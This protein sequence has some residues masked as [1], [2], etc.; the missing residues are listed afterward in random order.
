MSMSTPLLRPLPPRRRADDT[1]RLLQMDPDLGAELGEDEF[2]DVYRRLV[3]QV[4]A[5]PRPVV[6]TV[7]ARR[8]VPGGVVRA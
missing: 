3:G 7:D 1:V 4:G 5:H 2:S 8:V 6:A